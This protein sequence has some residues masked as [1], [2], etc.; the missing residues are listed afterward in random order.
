M[1]KTKNQKIVSAYLKGGIGNQLFQ[2]AY[3]QKIAK[4]NGF[5]I[6][7][8]TDFFQF[9]GYKR[10]S[11]LERLW[12]EAVIT[13]TLPAAS[14][15]VID[16]DAVDWPASAPNPIMM[17]L[18]DE[19]TH[20][21]IDGYWQDH[22]FLSTEVIQDIRDRLHACTSAQVQETH[23]QIRSIKN[24][25]CV[26]I[27]RHDY[28]H[29]GLVKEKYYIDTLK[30]LEKQF[31]KLQIFVFSDEPNYARHFLQQAG[32]DFQIIDANDDLSDLYLMSACDLQ[33]IANSS[34][35]WWAA[36]L[37]DA[38]NVCYPAPWSLI[39]SSSEHLCPKSWLK[40]GNSVEQHLANDD[41]S[42]SLTKEKF[43]TDREKFLSGGK[44]PSNWG[45][46]N[47]PC[48]NDAS[49]NTD[50]DAHYVYHTAWAMRRLLLTPVDTHIDIAS[51]LRF[52][53]LASAFQKIQF[54][55]YRPAKI[56]LNDL[57][58]GH[59]DLTSLEFKTQTIQ[60]LS[61][62]HVVEH[63]GLGRYGDDINFDG[64]HIAM[65]ELQRVLAPGGQLY[66]VVPVGKPTVVFNAHRIFS[67]HDIKAQF[68]ELDIVEFSYISDSG[69][70]I[71]HA[72]LSAAEN[73]N[74][75]CGCFIFKRP[76][77]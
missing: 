32:I 51:D 43:R 6:E 38:K 61:C 9:D 72:E 41:F 16:E 30:W 27:R 42:E 55:D 76:L 60:S 39:G 53:T 19:V 11:I 68:S 73:Q 5:A 66:F 49:A 75:A 4:D 54:L 33:V 52:V 67:P 1:T 35:S 45:I 18:P 17:T 2:I 74:Y 21:K 20:L 40:V 65:N 69:A 7:Y 14:T 26:H 46:A 12:P 62:M 15:A 34:Y 57:T 29:H 3:A 28:K 25:T 31:G 58:C 47:F 56:Q 8:S 77:I 59:A 24:A 23:Q 71:E 48:L 36:T 50:F 37:S 70:L 64:A 22:R 63:I 13:S 44:L 10:T